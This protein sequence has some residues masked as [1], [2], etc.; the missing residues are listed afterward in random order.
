M[1]Q[2]IENCQRISSDNNIAIFNIIWRNWFFQ[3]FDKYVMY[4]H[5]TL[6]I[7]KALMYMYI[8]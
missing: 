6:N 2:E 7:F 3:M 1:F 8:T 5:V 4:S